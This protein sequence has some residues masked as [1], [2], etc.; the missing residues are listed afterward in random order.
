VQEYNLIRRVNFLNETEKV[1]RWILKTSK[2]GGPSHSRWEIRRR[3]C[4]TG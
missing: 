3:P 1:K 4:A 2:T